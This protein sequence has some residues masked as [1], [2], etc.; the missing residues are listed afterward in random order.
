MPSGTRS[1]RRN[2]PLLFL[3]KGG[4]PMTSQA[5]GARRPTQ[6]NGMNHL[7]DTSSFPVGSDIDYE[8][9]EEVELLKQLT[10]D[11]WSFVNNFRWTPPIADL[12]MAFAIA[13]IIGLY[14]M[15]FE[16]GGK[17]ED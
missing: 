7:I 6:A 4:P 1:C 13:P 17:P 16:P 2:V 9:A 15:R 8:S 3:T 11:A 5:F 12:V 14:L 10:A